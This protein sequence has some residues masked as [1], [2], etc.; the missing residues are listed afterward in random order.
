MLSMI[1]DVTFMIQ[2]YVLYRNHTDQRLQ[3]S[4]SSLRSKASYPDLEGVARAY[5]VDETTP[6]L[7]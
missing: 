6:L 1:F 2:H 7:G 4:S 3:S 5:E